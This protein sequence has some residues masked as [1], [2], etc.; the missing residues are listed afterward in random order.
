MEESNVESTWP[1]MEIRLGSQAAVSP[2]EVSNQGK[3]QPVVMII[4]VQFATSTRAEVVMKFVRKV[5][6]EK[7]EAS[8]KFFPRSLHCVFV[9]IGKHTFMDLFGQIHI[10]KIPVLFCRALHSA[11]TK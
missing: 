4:P 11:A 6:E 8:F 2:F 5:R 1:F 9:S 7:D 10:K 3:L